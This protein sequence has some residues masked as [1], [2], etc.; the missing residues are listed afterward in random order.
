MFSRTTGITRGKEILPACSFKELPRLSLAAAFPPL[1]SLHSIA[2]SLSSQAAAAAPPADSSGSTA[3]AAPD[4]ASSP[5]VDSKETGESQESVLALKGEESCSIVPPEGSYAQELLEHIRRV[6]RDRRQRQLVDPQFSRMKDK[7]KAAYESGNT[8]EYQ[9]LRAETKQFLKQ[10]GIGVLPTS[11]LQMLLLG[12]AISLSTPAIRAISAD[13]FNWK[14]FAVEQPAWLESLA[15]PDASGLAAAVCWLVFVSTMAAG[16]M[17]SAKIQ[18]RCPS[19]PA[20]SGFASP[21]VM[22]GFGLVAATT[23]AFYSGTQLPAAALLFLVPAFALQSALMRIFRLRSVESLLHLVPEGLRP[24]QQTYLGLLQ[25]RQPALMAAWKRRARDPRYR[26][27]AADAAAAGAAA[28]SRAVLQLWKEL[29][30]ESAAAG[31]AKL[32]TWAQQVAAKQQQQQQQ[33]RLQQQQK[34]FRC[35]AAAAAPQQLLPRNV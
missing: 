3:A 14:S 22:R 34:R 25:R 35:Y 30:S 9:R 4:A 15:L 24:L 20:S 5:L 13:P 32:Q 18:K 8:K 2:A 1:R 26:E 6:E 21:G 27:A 17:V 12:L 7:M 23:F 10:H 31:P 19:P 33:L 28:T 11:F 16:W 29:S